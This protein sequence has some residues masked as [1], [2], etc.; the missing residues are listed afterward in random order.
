MEHQSRR[1][2]FTYRVE[3]PAGPGATRLW[4]PKP[5]PFPGQQ[6]KDVALAATVPIHVAR[7]REFGNEGYYLELPESDAPASI[8]LTAVVTREE[9][10]GVVIEPVDYKPNEVDSMRLHLSPTSHVP[11]D[12]A[13]ATQARAVVAD[14]DPPVVKARKLFDHLLATFEYDAAGCT[15]ERAP[16]LGDVLKACDLRSGTCTEWHSVYVAYLRALGIPAQFSFGFNLPPRGVDKKIRGYH[17]WAD[18]YLPKVGWIPVDVTEASKKPEQRD[19]YFG[20]VDCNRVQFLRGRDL[21]LEPRPETGLVDKWI[22]GH[23]ERAGHALSL[24]RLAFAHE[25]C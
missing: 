13:V 23:A 15:P 20:R 14:G 25:D 4:L 9:T 2:K 7:D 6:V 18:V 22:F 10:A 21:L 8:V 24:E 3:L 17:C 16:G 19:F 5:R 1:V 12:G 11:I